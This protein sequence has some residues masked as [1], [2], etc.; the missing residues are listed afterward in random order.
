MENAL[1]DLLEVLIVVAIGFGI[2]MM[3]LPPRYGGVWPR[4]QSK[5]S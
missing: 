4:K 3:A 2:I 5:R 1:L